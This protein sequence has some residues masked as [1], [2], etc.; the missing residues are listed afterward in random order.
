[1]AEYTYSLT[2]HPTPEQL[3]PLFAQADWTANRPLN[4]L[5]RML[6]HSPVAVSVWAGEKLVAYGRA[7]TDDLYRALIEDVIVDEPYRGQGIGAEVMRLLLQRLDHVEE[8]ALVCHD[9]L[10]PFYQRL[11]FEK[12]D[13][14]HM[15]I[16]KGS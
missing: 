6:D 9:H 8:I 4:A 10:I 15:H 16:W 3:L 11:G 14:A 1:M 2:N 13:M 12:F 7:V 5:Q